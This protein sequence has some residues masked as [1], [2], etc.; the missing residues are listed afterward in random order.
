[1]FHVEIRAGTQVV[2]RFNLEDRALWLEYLRP[3]LSDQPFTVEGHE[4]DPR[5]TRLKVL[6]G[7]ALRADQLGLG[8]G[9]QNAE[10]LAVDVT[11]RVLRDARAHLAQGA[12]PG[13]TPAPQPAPAEM[14]LEGRLAERV[15]G[16]LHAGPVSGAQ[17]VAIAGELHPAASEDELTEL[18]RGVVW[19]LLAAGQ[20]R[21]SRDGEDRQ[22]PAP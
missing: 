2:R 18:A 7:P 14:G 16:R 17:L 10:R 5:R 19:E 4:F 20:A 9:W 11:E 1:M 15:V 22:P 3:L 8:R 6:E 12:R 21:L 13:A